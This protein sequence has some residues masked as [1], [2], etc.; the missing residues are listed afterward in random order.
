LPQPSPDLVAVWYR[1]VPDNIEDAAGNLRSDFARRN[2]ARLVEVEGG[3]PVSSE[4]DKLGAAVYRFSRKARPHG[5]EQLPRHK[6]RRIVRLLAAGTPH[7]AIAAKV[8]V[9]LSTITR[10]R[11]EVRRWK[12]PDDAE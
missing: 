1:R 8:H 4:H 9:Q 11:R 7:R 6:L 12:D 10:L 3:T 2:G 5:H